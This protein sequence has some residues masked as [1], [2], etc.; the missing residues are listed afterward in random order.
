AKLA[1]FVVVVLLLRNLGDDR[2]GR[3]AAMVV[4]VTL[5]GV[6]ADLGLQTIFIR[7]VARDRRLFGRYLANLLSARLL[8]SIVALALLAVVLRLLSPALFPYTLAG[9]VLLLTTSY[10]S[11]LRAVFYI[12]GRLVFEAVAIVVE[13]LLLLG[14]TI[15]TVNRHGTW[16]TYLWV[17]SASY[18]FTC[19]FAFGILR[20][21]WRQQ[22]AVRFEPVFLRGLLA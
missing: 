5:L 13:A 12:R 10:S 15:L 18:L 11:L 16:D 19:L 6:V 1:V 9:F 20:W 2:Y 8:L 7:D 3:F 14:L 22:I 21:R 4:Y 17:Y